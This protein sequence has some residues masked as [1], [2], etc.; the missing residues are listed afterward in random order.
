MDSYLLEITISI[1]SKE[2]E[3]G[4]L[5]LDKILD[6]AGNKGTGAWTT[7]AA[8]ELGVAIP[9]ITS[10]LFA[11][12]QSFF[13]SERIQLSEQFKIKSKN[14]SSS[15]TGLKQLYQ[16]SRILNHRQGIELIKAASEKYDWNI[17]LKKLITV[18]TA[19]CI[20][21]SSLLLDIL[22]GLEHN[23]FFQS[24]H[25]ANYF[26][27][28]FTGTIEAYANLSSGHLPNPAISASMEYFKSLVQAD[29]NSNL[30]QAQRDFFGA[31]TFKMKSDPDGPSHH[32]DWAKT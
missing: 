10:A 22:K 27:K 9:T 12:Y 14:T 6:R 1:L 31:H 7:I 32:H 11:R 18:W 13:K 21:R 17:D 4:K 25:F 28:N 16:T 24:P 3:S 15:Y 29:G 19:G 26:A 8:A 5:V 30:I 20:I 23:D 2:D